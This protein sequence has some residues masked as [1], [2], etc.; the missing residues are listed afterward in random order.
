MESLDTT[1]MMVVVGGRTLFAHG[2]VAV[3]AGQYEVILRMLVAA[4]CGSCYGERKD[5]QV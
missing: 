4:K 3:T 2:D 1:G 5:G